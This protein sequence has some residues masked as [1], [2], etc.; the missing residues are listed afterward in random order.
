VNPH[1]FPSG[2]Q[3]VVSEVEDG[4]NVL[5]ELTELYFTQKERIEIE[6]KNERAINKLLKGTGREIK[7]A[8]ELLLSIHR[9]Q[10]DLGLVERHLGTTTVDIR[11][12]AQVLVE[13]Y[14]EKAAQLLNDPKKVGNVLG[15]FKRVVQLGAIDDE[16]VIDVTGEV[17]AD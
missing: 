16:G 12:S 8:R 14:G 1:T 17:D 13:G 2:H 9:I 10:S 5:S 7:E 4:L 15:L 6:V 3:R 11:Q